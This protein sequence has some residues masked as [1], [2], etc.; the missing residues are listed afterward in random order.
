MICFKKKFALVLINIICFLIF[1]LQNFIM[2]FIA[3]KLYYKLYD[4]LRYYSSYEYNN[5]SYYIRQRKV[6]NQSNQTNQSHNQVFI[7]IT[8]KFIKLFFCIKYTLYVYFNSYIMWNPTVIWIVYFHWLIWFDWLKT[9]RCHIVSQPHVRICTHS[10]IKK[11]HL[12]LF[13]RLLFF[14][15]VSVCGYMRKYI[16]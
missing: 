15:P 9:L 5:F 12:Q 1:I 2:I 10:F 13:M 16:L 6:L 7:V 8:W 14:K 4:F 11:P 3:N